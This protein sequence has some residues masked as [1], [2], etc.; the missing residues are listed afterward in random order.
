MSLTVEVS[1]I[2]YLKFKESVLGANSVIRRMD[3]PLKDITLDSV[4]SIK[5]RGSILLLDVYAVKKLMKTLGISKTFFDTLGKAYEDKAV[6]NEIIKAIKARKSGSI[7]IVYNCVM[8][9]IVNVYSTGAKFISD[10]QFF[11]TLE[12]LIQRTEGSHLRNIAMAQNGDLRAVIANPKLEFQ[13]G[14]LPD[15]LFTSG[16]T[17]ELSTEGLTSSFFTERLVCTNGMRAQNKICS[18][19]VD[20]AGKV[21]EFMAAIL[22]GGYYISSIEEFKKRINRCYHTRASLAEVLRTTNKVR[23]SLGKAG[24]SL[25]N[26]MSCSRIELAFGER[27]LSQTDY[28]SFLRTDIT[29]WE[30]VNEVTAVSSLI[31]QSRLSIHPNTNLKIQGIGGE[32]MFSKP[33]LIPSNIKQIF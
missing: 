27:Y 10:A 11:D 25:T 15:E 9:K 33:D 29:L 1:N 14:G 26:N 12:K 30:L 4:D 16:C 3:V 2:E 17:L 31:E 21:P 22:D 20:V 5:I 23:S 24:A 32:L 28:H 8:N 13:F 19:S 6:L 18:R 7:T